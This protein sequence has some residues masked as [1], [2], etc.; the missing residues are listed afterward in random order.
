MLHN[1]YALRNSCTNPLNHSVVPEVHLSFH[2]F[3]IGTDACFHP[4]AE[5]FVQQLSYLIIHIMH[6]IGRNVPAGSI[7]INMPLHKCTIRHIL[8]SRTSGLGLQMIYISSF[9]LSSSSSLESHLQKDATL[10]NSSNFLFFVTHVSLYGFYY[11]LFT[12]QHWALIKVSTAFCRDS[13]SSKDGGHSGT[14]GWRNRQ[15]FTLRE[16][17]RPK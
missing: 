13:P 7:N 2:H 3:G 1:F 11:P 8:A 16:T 12:S 4:T 5:L 6:L 10:S 15:C 17:S 14:L 9:P